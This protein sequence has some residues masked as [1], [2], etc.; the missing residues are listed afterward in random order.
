[1]RKRDAT[2]AEGLRT[3]LLRHEKRRKLPGI[4]ADAERECLIEQLI[5]SV[6]RVK[7]PV[8]IRIRRIGPS[9]SDPSKEAFDPIKAALIHQQ[10][11]E[12]DEA[13]WL[14][15]LF[16]Q[17]GKHPK[18]GYRLLR[19]VYS[20]TDSDVHW[21]WKRTSSDVRAFSN[22]LA[23]QSR[24]WERDGVKRGFG[25]HRTHETVESTPATVESYVAW[26]H[27]PRSHA[28]LV[29][30]A[31]DSAQNHRGKAFDY[32]YRSMRVYRFGRLA[33]FDYLAMLGK[34]GLA[35]IEPSSTYILEATGPL[36]GAQLLYCGVKTDKSHDKDLDGWLVELGADLG[37]GQQVVEDALCNWQKSPAKFKMFRG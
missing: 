3:G 15:F 33:K 18:S 28:Q 11:G 32:L 35:D 37:V 1:M 17:F 6:R 9:R 31:Q 24:T 36:Q 26:V 22:W 7:Y 12:L 5:E 20:G 27:P 23:T 8:A 16:V 21:T 19:D 14:V 34:L 13:F 2:V 25:A 29:Q 4:A 30:E 10:H